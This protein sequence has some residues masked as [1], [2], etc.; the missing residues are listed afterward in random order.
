MLTACSHRRR[1]PIA[2]DQAGH[3]LRRL[4][5]QAR[6]HVRVGIQRDLNGGVAQRSLTTLAGMP[7]ASAALA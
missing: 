2:E 7:A 3:R 1:R 5:V 6:Q 4:L